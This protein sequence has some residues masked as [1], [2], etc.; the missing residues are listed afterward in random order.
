M[1]L[2]IQTN[3]TIKATSKPTKNLAALWQQIHYLA[4]W[5]VAKMFFRKT[6]KDIQTQIQVLIKDWSA[7]HVELIEARRLPPEM[8]AGQ[9]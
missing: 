7:D 2:D 4:S 1:N 9:I 3:S 8:E 5:Y 6:E